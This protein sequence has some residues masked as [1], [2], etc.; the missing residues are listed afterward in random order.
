MDG[1]N[2]KSLLPKKTAPRSSSTTGVSQKKSPHTS[3]A[4]PESNPEAVPDPSSNS[5]MKKEH[6]PSTTLEE[7]ES[8]SGSK[9]QMAAGRLV[10]RSFS[11]RRHEAG[12]FSSHHDN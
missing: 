9:A 8:V 3:M 6:V 10:E 7:K 1:K 12:I 2:R 5:I 11:T 4:I